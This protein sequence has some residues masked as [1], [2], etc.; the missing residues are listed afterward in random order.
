ML[1]VLCYERERNELIDIM[2]NEYQILP[3]ETGKLLT[4]LLMEGKVM[5]VREGH[6]LKV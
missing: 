2:Q 4:Q 5:E 6:Y 3:S 1:S